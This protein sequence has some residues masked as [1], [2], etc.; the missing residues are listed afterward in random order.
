M[1]MIRRADAER[2][3]RD[4]IA[5]DLGD[6]ARQAETMRAQ[7]QETAKKILAEAQA[8][9]EEMLGSASEEGRADGR[10]QGHQEG[11]KQGLEEGRRQALAE[12][13]E[14]IDALLASWGA[15]LENYE[16]E[17]EQIMADARRDVLRLAVLAAEKIT[18]RVIE[19]DPSIVEGVV[20][21]VVMSVL[22]PTRLVLRVHP[23]DA[24]RATAVVGPLVQRLGE[25]AHAEVCADGSIE[26]GSCLVET[27]GGAVIDAT[28]ATK[29]RRIAEA[30]LPGGSDLIDQP[31]SQPDAAEESDTDGDEQDSGGV[32]LDDGRRG[33]AA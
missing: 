18:R 32:R 9:R 22:E 26:R 5:L 12:Q 27:A 15:A 4:A 30:V 25:S 23:E 8:K 19:I 33:A 21:D 6:L 29:L 28:I 10:A 16:H 20:R 3:A 1:G 24:E 14:A 2:V 11:F 7:A 17:R 13:A 31:Q